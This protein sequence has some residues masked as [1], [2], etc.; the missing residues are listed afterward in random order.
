MSDG[1]AWTA[2]ELT[3]KMLS[4]SGRKL[5]MGYVLSAV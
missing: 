2:A 4:I 5:N 3:S 1:D